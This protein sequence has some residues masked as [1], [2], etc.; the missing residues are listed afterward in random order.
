MK[1]RKKTSIVIASFFAL[2]CQSAPAPEAT[3]KPV[4]PGT[5]GYV[6]Q[7]SA[8]AGGSHHKQSA[9]EGASP[10]LRALNKA[11]IVGPAPRIR[12][13]RPNNQQ[14]VA[15]GPV[16]LKLQVDRWKLA[17]PPGNHIHVKIDDG[18]GFAVRNAAELIALDERY[19]EVNGQPLSEGTHVVRVFLARPNHESVKLPSAFDSVV[20]HYRSRTPGF[21]FDRSRPL[22]T[23]SRSQGCA[24]DPDRLLDFFV[25]NI[26][27]LSKKGFRVQYVIDGVHAGTLFSWAPYQIRDLSERDHTVRLTLVRPDGSPAPGMF[28]DVTTTIK[29]SDACPHLGL[30][31]EDTDD[32]DEEVLE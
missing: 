27:G 30:I 29:V 1:I 17:S 6:S 13:A 28:N 25:T 3:A 4:S 23:Y 22:L 16:S 14:L 8:A 19:E 31:P 9:G 32:E 7:G 20:F 21:T 2:S 18:K 11:P 10:S 5:E 24:S 12:I 26:N 15:R